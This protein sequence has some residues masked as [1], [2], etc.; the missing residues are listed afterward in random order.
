MIATARLRS[1]VQAIFRRSRLEADMDH[2]LNFHIESYVEDLCRSGVPRQEAL[3]RARAEFGGIDRAKEQCREARGA[4]VLESFLF[5]IRYGLRMLRKSPGFAILAIAT[6]ALGIG[7]TTAVFTLVNAVLLRALPYHDPGRLV[8]LWETNPDV[9]GVPLEAWGAINGD[10][11]D[12]QKQSRSFSDLALFN[13]QSLNLSANETAIGIIGSRVTGDFF[14]LLGVA[15]LLGRTFDADD[16]EPGKEQVAVIS[17]ALWQSRFG[18]DSQVLG[19][20]LLL[21]ARSYR[22]V[23]VMPAGFEF[24]HGSESIEMSGKTTDLW[25]PWA[26]TAKEKASRAD[27]PGN[28]IGRLRPH[29][30]VAEAQS[31]LNTITAPLNPLHLRMLRHS[32][33]LVR[34]FDATITGASR[35]ALLIFM[36]AVLLVL[37]IACSNVA[38]LVLARA[39][40]RV[41]EV[42]VRAALG[43]SRSR[44][45]RQMLAESLGLAL[46]GGMLGVLVAFA[47]LRLMMRLNPGNIPRLDEVSVDWRVLLFCLAISLATVVLFGLFPAVST[48]RCNLNEALKRSA[49]RTLK[50]S[51][52]HA[53]QALIVCELALTLVL[54]AG[55]GLLIRSFLKLEAVN[56]GFTLPSTVTMSIR[57]DGRYN[58]PETQDQFFRTVLDRTKSLPGVEAAGAITHLPLCNCESLAMREVEGHPY[59]EKILFEERSITPG[60]FPAMGIPLLEGRLLTEDDVAGRPPVAIVS[61][62]FANKY[63][64]NEGA[65][66]KHIARHAADTGLT[67]SNA[68]TIIGVVADV[69]NMDLE[70]TPPM[71]IYTP[72]WQDGSNAVSIAARTSL[73]ANQLASDMRAIVR[74]LDPAVA[75]ADVR[76]MNQLV[77]A[78]QAERRF[79]T[80]LLTVFAGIALFLSLVGLYGLMAYSVEQRTGEI[81]IRMALGAQRGN[82]MRLILKEGSTLALAGVAIG[83]ACAIV[84]TRL[85]TSLLYATKPSDPTT[86]FAVAGLFTVISVAACCIP[87]LRATRVEPMTALRYE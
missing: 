73:S 2:E 23:G 17:H 6:L 45:I 57:L 39:T 77:S 43:A 87:A 52:N 78:A 27:D 69:R 29:V 56:K 14:H 38:G 42:S 66:G 24:P 82:V 25:I 79:Q 68:W 72:L 8:F 53:R 46:S 10:F 26:M 70:S 19:K 76:T 71:Q 49:G 30:S 40:G 41:Q 12:W 62:G 1:W 13:T 11:Y 4:G 51:A 75:V 85:I 58:H 61:R 47:G 60:Y 7:A 67:S 3:R 50:G 80:T 81:G 84:V 31:E 16:D 15:P 35:R 37:L 83:F 5:D 64:P 54:L 86:F 22:I 65:L 63:F 34:P 32:Q 18:S 28:A 21:N 44:L 36:G 74:A 33:V 55:S 59:D 20:Q 9:P 48:S